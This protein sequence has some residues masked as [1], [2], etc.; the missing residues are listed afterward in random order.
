M[1]TPANGWANATPAQINEAAMELIAAH[2]CIRLAALKK[3]LNGHGIDAFKAMQKLLCSNANPV[4]LDLVL[5]GNVK[6]FK[7]F[8]KQ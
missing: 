4:V 2:H 6:R 7:T 3:A 1:K 5:N 8:V